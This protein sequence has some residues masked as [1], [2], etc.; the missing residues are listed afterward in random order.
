LRHKGWEIVE[1]VPCNNVLVAIKCVIQATIFVV[2]TY[3]EVITSNN[4]TWIFVHGYCVQDWC[5]IF[6]LVSIEHIF[7]GSNTENMMKVIM[8]SLFNIGHLTKAKVPSMLLCFD[9]CIWCEYLSRCLVWGYSSNLRF[10]C[11]PFLQGSTIRHARPIWQFG[12]F[13][14]ACGGMP[15]NLF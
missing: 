12:F 15:R 13:W 7:E 2:L 9:L 1:H 4:H 14:F 5:R 6:I 10:A 3:D 11:V 8:S